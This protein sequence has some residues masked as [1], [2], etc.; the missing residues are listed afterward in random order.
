MNCCDDLGLLLV[1]FDVGLFDGYFVDVF[2]LVF[3][4]SIWLLLFVWICEFSCVGLIEL[5][6]AIWGY[7]LRFDYF[8]GLTCVVLF[9]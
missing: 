8:V 4:V 1:A 5:R 3:V 6:L 2:I 9:A 7:C